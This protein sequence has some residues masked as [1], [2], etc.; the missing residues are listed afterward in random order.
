MLLP[1]LIRFV[2]DVKEDDQLVCD[3]LL[4]RLLQRRDLLSAVSVPV[5]ARRFVLFFPQGN[6]IQVHNSTGVA[7]RLRLISD[8]AVCR[9]VTF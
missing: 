1:N 6:Q 4:H 2:F 9:I 3:A 7:I 5:A 8:T